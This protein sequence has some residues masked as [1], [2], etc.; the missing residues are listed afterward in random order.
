MRREAFSTNKQKNPHLLQLRKS[1][2]E[3]KENKKPSEGHKD[4]NKSFIH[5]MVNW[6]PFSAYVSLKKGQD[7]GPAYAQVVTVMMFPLLGPPLPQELGGE[8][9]L[10]AAPLPLSACFLS[11]CFR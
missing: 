10:P 11:F 9:W 1:I 7:K 5:L 4:K 3:Q 6:I 2:S 8:L